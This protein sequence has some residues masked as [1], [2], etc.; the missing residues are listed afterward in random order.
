MK[1]QLRVP[2]SEEDFSRYFELRWR[3]LRAPWHQPRG[4]ER[5]EFEDDS[6]HV[7]ICDAQDKVC[8]VGRIHRED[9]RQAQIRYMAVE[10]DLRGRG[11]GAQ[12]LQAL[13]DKAR[14]W[15]CQ[16]VTL[17]ARRAFKGFYLAQGYRVM[18]PSHTLF[19]RV[20]HVLMEKPLGEQN[21]G[22]T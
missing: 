16:R 11:L 13:E 5:D 1:W 9:T 2:A 15:G 14:E 6:Y 18:M 20:Q 19:N 8:A 10:T 7:M 22:P 21:G 3:I 4:S 17:H 12:V